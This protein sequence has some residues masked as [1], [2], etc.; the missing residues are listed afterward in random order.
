MLSKIDDRLIFD[1]TGSDPQA[2]KGINLPYHATFGVCFSAVLST[3]ASR[4]AEEPWHFSPD[5][6]HRSQRELL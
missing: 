3:L 5:R 4:P 1:F 2:S 6:S